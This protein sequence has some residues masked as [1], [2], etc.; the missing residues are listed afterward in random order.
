MGCMTYNKGI[1][2]HKMFFIVEEIE[3][4]ITVWGIYI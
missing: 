1:Q 3:V 4:L 2:E